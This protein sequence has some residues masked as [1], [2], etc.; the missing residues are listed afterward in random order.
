IVIMFLGNLIAFFSFPGYSMLKY[1]ISHLA[2]SP[3]GIY[4]NIGFILSGLF[5][6]PFN[7]SLGKAV[8]G[9]SVNNNIKKI[10]LRISII[11]CVSLSLI[12]VFPAYPENLVILTIHG[13]LALIFFVC[14]SITFLLYGYIFLRSVKFLKV[15]AYLSFIVT[16]VLFIYIA[17][18]LSILEWTS[19]FG[20]MIAVFFTSIFLIYKKY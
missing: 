10:V 15:H 7:I 6:I 16:G 11:D 17:L 8:N 5:A 12:G 4:F 20:I 1:N 3:G 2:L 19:F 9:E 13:L 14:T 18:R